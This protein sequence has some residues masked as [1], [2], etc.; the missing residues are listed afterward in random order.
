MQ[1]STQGETAEVPCALTVRATAV[2]ARKS[3][4]NI[5]S[6]GRFWGRKEIEEVGKGLVLSSRSRVEA[7]Q[8]LSE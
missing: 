2:M 3:L 1:A 7:L 5:F 4:G 6:E 8:L